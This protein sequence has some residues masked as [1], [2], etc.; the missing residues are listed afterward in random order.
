MGRRLRVL[1]IDDDEE[2]FILTQG[3]LTDR[4]YRSGG[5]HQIRFELEWANTYEAALETIRKEQHDVY[6][7]DYQLGVRDGLQLLR[8]VIACGCKTPIIMMTGQGNY[9]VD[10]EAM[11]AGATDYLAKEEVTAPLLERTIRYAIERKRTEDTLRKAHDELELRVEERTRALRLANQLLAQ[12]IEELRSE[13]IERLRV[14]EA[15]EAERNRL[16]SLLDEIPAYVYLQAPDYSIRFANCHFYERFGIPE[17]RP[18]YEI[19][20]KK[21]QPCED[22]PTFGVFETRMP[23][24]WEWASEDGRSYQ[25]YDYP[26][27]DIDDSP[28][29]L[30]LGIDITR[31]KQVEA[32][33]AQYNRDLLA[34]SQAEHN[35]RQLAEG[36][37]Q[38]TIAMSTSL[39]LEEVL[40]CILEQI[41]LVIACRAVAI[42]LMEGETV[43]I[44]RHR[45]FDGLPETWALLSDGFRLDTLPYLQT[46]SASYQPVLI[47]DT[48]DDP[49][50]PFVAGFEWI[51][52]YAAAPLHVG[53][54][55]NGFVYILSDQPGFYVTEISGRLSAFAAQAAVAIQNARL[56]KELENALDHEQAI[57]RQLIQA[58]KYAAMGRMVAS[59]AHEL[60]NPLQTIRNCLF[61]TRQEI[62]ADHPA[63]AYLVMAASETQRLSKL[64][65]QLR[66]LT[67][68][69]RDGPFQVFEL[70]YLLEE[71]HAMLR[72]QLENYQVNWKKAYPQKPCSMQG[73]VDQLKQ[74]FINISA[75][76]IEAMQPDGGTITVELRFLNPS[77]SG[78]GTQVGIMFS[79]TGP[80]ISM[81][82]LP[83]VFEPFFTTKSSGLGLGLSICCEIVELHGGRITVE[84]QPGQGAAFIVWLPVQA[85]AK[86]L[87]R[88]GD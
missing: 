83:K 39:N 85:S 81:E 42:L 13:V 40:D 45:G 62:I 69:R 59:V 87:E 53:G 23:I 79:D 64:V 50:W 74:V 68:P 33:L 6:L 36:L 11:S 12:T 17:G 2:E 43:R 75:N 9:T 18:C 58:E 57:R 71:V 37:A 67:R 35:Q 30:E 32:Q 5:G 51:R 14:E 80:G 44:S 66:E 7:L 29:V 1:L 16:F 38:A 77:D 10:L 60:N 21:S 88:E 73:V 86:P 63:H 8:E 70:V 54:N 24:E 19:I 55:I 34:I 26:F 28:L 84:S 61:L 76:A 48:K 20:Q 82:N 27:T 22:C 4:S 3:L 47:S 56:Y 41:Q 72:P 52:S 31:R 25:V 78:D 49:A 46:M 65:T 15:L